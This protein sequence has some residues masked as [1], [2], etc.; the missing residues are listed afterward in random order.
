MHRS[1]VVSAGL[2]RFFGREVAE[3]P[4]VATS[5]EHQGKVST[6]MLFLHY[7][8]MQLSIWLPH[9]P[10]HF[11][12]RCYMLFTDHIMPYF[13]I[14]PSLGL[15][16]SAIFLYRDVASFHGGAKPGAA[17]CWGRWVN[18]DKEI[19]LQKDEWGESKCIFQLWTHKEA[20]FLVTWFFSF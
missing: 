18:L 7:V 19:R 16:P 12:F 20:K 4:I 3:L 5:R 10:V 14:F 1:V 17:C 8:L 9:P 15:F 11:Y 6:S 2:L 13:V